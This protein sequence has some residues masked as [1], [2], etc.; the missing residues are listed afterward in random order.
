ME[1]ILAHQELN[2]GNR[3]PSPGNQGAKSRHPGSESS[4]PRTFSRQPWN[5]VQATMEPNPRN[6]NCIQVTRK[7]STWNQEVNSGNQEPSLANCGTTSREP[8]SEYRQPV[9]FSR[10]P[11]NKVQASLGPSPVHQK[12]V[13]ATRNLHQATMK[14]SPGNQEVNLGNKE[15]S[16][17]NHGTKSREPGNDESRQPGTFTRQ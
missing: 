9:I 13:Q 15:P 4:Q 1:P 6:Q 16:P 10:Q 17:F 14:P 7:I 2:P 12:V 3:E 11:W 8:G 5:Q